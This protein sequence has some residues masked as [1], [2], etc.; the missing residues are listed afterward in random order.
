[1]MTGPIL[2][3]QVRFFSLVRIIHP[4][5][6]TVLPVYFWFA[7][8]SSGFMFLILSK[9]DTIFKLGLESGHN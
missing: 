5:L 1:M 7:V 3:E 9:W 2:G 6:K 4:N 8:I